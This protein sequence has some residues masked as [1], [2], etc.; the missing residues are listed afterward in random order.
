L[1]VLFI[2]GILCAISGLL[3]GVSEVSALLEF[4]QRMVVDFDCVTLELGPIGCP[5]VAEN[6]YQHAA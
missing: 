2:K 4:T 5:V 3:R 6:N 1:I